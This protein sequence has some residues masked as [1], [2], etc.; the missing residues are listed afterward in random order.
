MLRQFFVGG[1]VSLVTIAIHALVMTIVVHVARAMG[2]K[3]H[4]HSSLFLIA[5]MI[6]DRLSSDGGTCD[7]SIRVGFGILDIRRG[8]CGGQSRIFCVRELRDSRLRRHTSGGA[9]ATAWPYN[10]DERHVAV[11]MVDRSHFRGPTANVGAHPRSQM[12]VGFWYE[13][14]LRAASVDVCSLRQS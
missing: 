7:R 12:N 5:V 4:T 3:Q 9:L 8:A 11:W 10:R 13:R 2:T 14:D 6:P 1:G